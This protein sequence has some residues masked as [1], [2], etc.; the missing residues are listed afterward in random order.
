VVLYGAIAGEAYFRGVAGER[1]AVRNSGAHAVVEGVGDH[2][3]EYMTGGTVVVLGAT[4]RNFAAGMSGGLAYVLDIDG[5]FAKRCN[6]AMVDLEPVLTEPEQ[7]GRVSRDVWHMGQSDEAVLRGFIDRHARNTG[8]KR[9][10]EILENWAEWRGRFVKVFPKE[11]KRALAE[12]AAS[13][14]KAVA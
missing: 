12:N 4:G 3:C 11:Y 2:G 10:K 5:E 7:Q 8:S 1:F 9:A 14:N 13:Q 6:T